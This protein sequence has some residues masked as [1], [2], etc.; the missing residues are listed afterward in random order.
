L[1]C[2]ALAAGLDAAAPQMNDK[3]DGLVVRRR[4]GPALLRRH[5]SDPLHE[6]LVDVVA[7]VGEPDPRAQS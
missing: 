5:T 1:P 3:A 7:L 6:P 2:S 4:R